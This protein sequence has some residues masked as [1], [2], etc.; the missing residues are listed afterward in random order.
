M[1]AESEGD[2]SSIGDKHLIFQKNGV[3][4]G[5]SCGLFQVRVIENRPSCDELL[6]TDFN[7]RV[8]RSL[9]EKSGWSIWSSYINESYKKH[10]D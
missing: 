4:M 6:N 8:A 5:M 7:I 2:P 9:Y 10:L 1:L 3:D